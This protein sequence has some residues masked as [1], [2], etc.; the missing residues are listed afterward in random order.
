[1]LTR[2]GSTTRTKVADRPE[3]GKVEPVFSALG[4]ELPG[5]LEALC[6]PHPWA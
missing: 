2:T 1:M 5:P 4:V 6:T 3:Y